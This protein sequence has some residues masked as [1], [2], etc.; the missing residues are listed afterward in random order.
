MYHKCTTS[1]YLK[2]CLNILI[3]PFPRKYEVSGKEM[4]GFFEIYEVSL[5]LTGLL[6]VELGFRQI[7]IIQRIQCKVLPSFIV[8]MQVCYQ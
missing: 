8:R 2:K 5:A 1:L 6:F 3:H 7:K 4:W